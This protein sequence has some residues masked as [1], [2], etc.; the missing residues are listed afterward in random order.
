M[1]GRKW[2]KDVVISV[3]QIENQENKQQFRIMNF[4]VYHKLTAE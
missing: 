2:I 1:N 3:N 4:S